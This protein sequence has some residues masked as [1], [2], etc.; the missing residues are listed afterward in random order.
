MYSIILYVFRSVKTDIGV[1]VAE[2]AVSSWLHL[3][4]NEVREP[5]H[6]GHVFF[7]VV[8]VAWDAYEKSWIPLGIV[9]TG[10]N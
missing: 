6:G 8:V 9:Q 10:Q 3:G 2:A 7:V 1:P 5:E 4:E